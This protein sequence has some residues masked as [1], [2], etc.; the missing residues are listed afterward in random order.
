MKKLILLLA[1]M[2][3]IVVMSSCQK[4][5]EVTVSKYFQ[6]M[7]HN[8]KDTMATMSFEPRDVEYKAFEILSIEEPVVG[9]L[10]LPKL[11]KKAADLEKGRKDQVLL[12][13]EKDD[14]LA[15]AEDELEET[16][17]RSKRDELEKKIEELQTQA[18][19]EKQ[20]VKTMQLEI[21]QLDKAIEREKALITLSTGMRDNLEMFSGET[22]LCKVTVKVTLENDEVQNYIFLLRK[23]VLKL[24]DKQTN[25]RL[26]ILKLMSEEDYEK[27]MQAKE[28]EKAVG[29]TEEVTEEQPA[30][31]EQKEEETTG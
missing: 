15:E 7:Q 9:E 12:A 6:A 20:K 11:L 24:Q 4:A 1:V 25:G 16:R 5:E 10:Q 28:E 13:V 23:D 8:D 22:H 19:E 30:T 14:E 27:E 26:V 18:E 29:E 3:L 2:G 31:E 17:R 21:N